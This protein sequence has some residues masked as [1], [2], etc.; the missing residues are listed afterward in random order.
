VPFGFI[1]PVP[2]LPDDFRQAVLLPG[3]ARQKAFGA[4]L[5]IRAA[6]SFHQPNRI[7]QK[8]RMI[9]GYRLL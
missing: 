9:E 8:V 3:N 1:A 6:P 7:D 4:V 5:G 2:D